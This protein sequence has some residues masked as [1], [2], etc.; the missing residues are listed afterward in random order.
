[1]CMLYPLENIR[2]RLQ[3]QVK[4]KETRQ[5]CAGSAGATGA[6]Q[7][8]IVH[9]HTHTHALPAATPSPDECISPETPHISK[10][11][12][13]SVQNGQV[14]PPFRSVPLDAHRSV[15]L[16]TPRLTQPP[17]APQPLTCLACLAEGSTT[18]PAAVAASSGDA[19]AIAAVSGGKGSADVC[20]THVLPSG[21]IVYDFRGSLD[22]VRQVAAR[23]GVWKLYSGLSSA[24][25]GV[26]ASSAVYFFFYYSLKSLVL[27]QSGARSMGPLHNLL[28]ASVSGVLNVFITLP[29][30]L[31]NTRMTVQRGP[32]QYRG[33]WDA[34]R[35]I[36]AEEGFA[37]FYRG[38]LPSLIL[39]SNPAIQFVV[40]EQCI[41]IMSKRAAAAAALA[42]AAQG[43]AVAGGAAAAS[44][45]PAVVHLSSLQ[46]FMLG[47]FA[48]AVATVA[49]YPYQVVKSRQ[50]ASRSGDQST[51]A[52]CLRMW[53][54]EGPAAFF[55]G[56]NAKMSQTVLNSAFMF[57]VYER[58]LR[59][60]L[61]FLKWM[62]AEYQHL[63]KAP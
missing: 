18:T 17:A 43:V 50:Q 26:G 13:H 20:G 57:A 6:S 55:N 4:R 16:H 10:S 2:T 25:V 22:C 3:V 36:H 9:T 34:V 29:I 31:V 62:S 12:G 19:T 49:T 35:R 53:R 37:G 47:A 1:M 60:I 63:P 38:L 51:W 24:L 5:A 23:E 56:M 32:Q 58:L 48:K 54:E 40:Y 15:P 59:V 52:L 61:R 30:W 8:S 7:Q 39:V 28:V 11:Q 41:R 45:A 46:Y 14:P 33:L 27:A 42:T 44:A 21:E